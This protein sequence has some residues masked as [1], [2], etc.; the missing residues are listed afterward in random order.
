MI[1][2][3]TMRLRIPQA[4]R[5]IFWGLAFSLLTGCGSAPTPIPVGPLVP[6]LPPGTLTS[7]TTTGTDVITGD[8]TTT[9]D[10]SGDSTGVDTYPLDLRPDSSG[11]LC[12]ASGTSTLEGVRLDTADNPCELSLADI[13]SVPA[14]FNYSVI[15]DKDAFGVISV[16]LDGGECD[17]PDPGSNLRVQETIEGNGQKY[18]LCDTGLCMF[19]PTPQTVPQGTWPVEFSWDGTNWNGPSDTGNPHGPLFVPG[20]YTFTVQAEGVLVLN[21]GTQQTWNMTSSWTFT[22]TE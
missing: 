3:L 17:Q 21:D 4:T 19:Q 6:G 12:Q 5:T 15:A 8:D 13:Q 22:L 1:E 11:N 18:C 7:D 9:M 14:V 10:Q 20:A 16:P 2:D